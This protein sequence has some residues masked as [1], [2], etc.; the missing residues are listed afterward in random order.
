MFNESASFFVILFNNIDSLMLIAA[1]LVGISVIMPILSS[2]GYPIIAKIGFI[3]YMS[4]LIFSAKFDENLNVEY[5]NSF[6]GFALVIIQEFMIGYILG[7]SVYFLTSS[8]YFAGQIIDFQLGYSM[9]SIF[10]PVSQMQLP[11]SGNIMSLMVSALM[12]ITG[13]LNVFLDAVFF[14]YD[15]LP[16]GMVDFTQF[17]TIMQLFTN[18]TVFFFSFG[19]RVSMPILGTILVIDIALGLLVK[20]SPQMNVFVVGMPIKVLIGLVLFYAIM[21]MMVD[22]YSELF[23]YSSQMFY[24][25]INGFELKQ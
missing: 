5:A 14:S 4:M 22:V 17:G 23:N 7:F 10:D 3:F 6:I 16:I 13:A 15:K 25:I 2:K 9:V 21:P 18:A 8:I 19:L 24:G 11:I 12:I 20:A 1:R